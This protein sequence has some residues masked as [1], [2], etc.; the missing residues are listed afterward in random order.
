MPG[1]PSILLYGRDAS[2]LD[3][4]SLVLQYPGYRV[5]CILESAELGQRLRLSPLDLLI[6]C[7]TLSPLESEAAIA[8]TKLRQPWA[9]VLALTAADLAPDLQSRVASMS[10]RQGPAQLLKVVELLLGRLATY[11]VAP[12]P[13]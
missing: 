1:A 7:H 5:E 9:V 3:S 4:R 12:T 2:L 13:E 6:L 8:A 10:S 11:K